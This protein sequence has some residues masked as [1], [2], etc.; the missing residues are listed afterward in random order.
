L[1]LAKS[2]KKHDS[3]TVLRKEKYMKL[4]QETVEG[5][6]PEDWNDKEEFKNIDSIQVFDTYYIKFWKEEN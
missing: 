5:N 2:W 1:K 3:S 4:M 6:P